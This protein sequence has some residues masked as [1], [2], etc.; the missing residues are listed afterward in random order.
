MLASLKISPF[1]FQIDDIFGGTGVHG[2]ENGS[3]APV[4]QPNRVYN[5]FLLIIFHP[6]SS[7]FI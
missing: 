4:S 5:K 6:L 2:K 3:A 1:C 7:L